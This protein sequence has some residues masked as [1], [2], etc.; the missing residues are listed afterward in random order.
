MNIVTSGLFMESIKANISS[1]QSSPIFLSPLFVCA[2]FAQIL[3]TGVSIAQAQETICHKYVQIDPTQE[4]ASGPRCRVIDN[5]FYFEGAVT[6]DLYYELRDYHP[7][8]T[9]IELN[10]YGG[11][12][13]AGYKIAE[14]VRSRNITTHVR[15]GAKCASACTLIFQAGI[16]R[17]ASPGVRF[18]YH[19]VR[20]SNLWFDNWLDLRYLKG[21][22]TGRAF[23]ATQFEEIQKETNLFWSQMVKYGMDPSFIDYYRSLPEDE[24]WFL[25]GN[26]TRTKNLIIPVE[27][28]VQYGI[29]NEVK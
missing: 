7:H 11:L 21:R 29:V 3:F 25:E 12:V 18:L 15:T 16:H 4:P 17:S 5:T 24:N 19:S 28:L 14:L 27:E 8:V 26:F 10:S 20:L 1:F 22:E 6:E 9:A 23:L 13:E 2:L